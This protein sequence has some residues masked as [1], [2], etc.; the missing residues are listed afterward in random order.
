MQSCGKTIGPIHGGYLEYHKEARLKKGIIT[1]PDKLKGRLVECS[2]TIKGIKSTKN[3]KKYVS[4]YWRT[5]TLRDPDVHLFGLEEEDC[6]RAF[7][8]FYGWS[9][10]KTYPQYT[11]CGGDARRTDYEWEGYGITLHFRVDYRVTPGATKNTTRYPEVFFRLDFTS[12][13]YSK[14]SVVVL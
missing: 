5:F 3:V 1:I 11:L 13:D 4:L 14:Y 8:T 7:V 12:F 10:T 2:L 9:D 6:G